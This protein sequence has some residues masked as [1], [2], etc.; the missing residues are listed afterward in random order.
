MLV[1]KLENLTLLIELITSLKYL[2]VI[3]QH[4]LSA[5]VEFIIKQNKN[6]CCEVYILAEKGPL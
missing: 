6:P 2:F 1:D 5:Y 3:Q 4:V